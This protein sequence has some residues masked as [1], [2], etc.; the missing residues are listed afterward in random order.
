MENMASNVMGQGIQAQESATNR[1]YGLPGMA[2][3]YGAGEAGNRSDYANRALQAAGG[4]AGLGSQ[5]A[6]LPMQYA[7][8]MGQ[9]GQMTN[10]LYALMGGTMNPYMTQQT[11]NPST[12]QNM[13]GVLGNTDWGSIFGGGS[14]R[15]QYPTSLGYGMTPWQWWGQPN[16]GPVNVNW[17]N[18]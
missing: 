1:M 3:Q 17:G 12:F 2:Y 15:P 18:G 5:Y 10:P 9:L 8:L 16:T 11:Y 14:S 4:L 13:M 7:G 6:Q